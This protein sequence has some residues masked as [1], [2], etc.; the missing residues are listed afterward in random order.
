MKSPAV[1][2]RPLSLTVLGPATLSIAAREVAVSRKARALLA[3]AALSDASEETRERLCRA[4]DGSF[5]FLAGAA[6]NLQDPLCFRCV[7]QIHGVA[8]DTGGLPGCVD[9]R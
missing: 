5:L 7:P 3:Y 2:G 1:A 6:R 4:L 8:R 9:Q